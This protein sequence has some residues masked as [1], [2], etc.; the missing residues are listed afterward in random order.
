MVNGS[1]QSELNRFFQVVHDSPVTLDSV[2]T[3]AFCKAR[4]KFSHTAFKELNTCLV[5]TFYDSSHVKNWKGFRLL[6]V[7]GSVTTLPETPELFEHYGTV[8]FG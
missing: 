4:K 5:D 6:A 1:I 2:S 7:D 3:A 8:F